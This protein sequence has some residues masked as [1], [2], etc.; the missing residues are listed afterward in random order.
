LW[1]APFVPGA[2]VD[3]STVPTQCGVKCKTNPQGV[4]TCTPPNVCVCD[5]TNSI[6]IG[7]LFYT[8]CD[9]LCS[10]NMPGQGNALIILAHQLIAAKLNILNGASAPDIQQAIIDGDA[11]VD[12]N[13]ILTD[14]V[15]PLST[16]GQQM[17]AVAATLDLYNNG[18][19]MLPHCA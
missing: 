8:Q 1:P 10:L 14:V 16:L 17:I 5:A 9:L 11:L 2:S 13:N 18:D 7:S 4:T 3:S 6:Q 12:G 19:G 15:D